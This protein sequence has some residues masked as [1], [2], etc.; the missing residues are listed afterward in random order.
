MLLTY[1]YL[2]G[3]RMSGYQYYE[4]MNFNSSPYGYADQPTYPPLLYAHDPSI[5]IKDEPESDG[6]L[7]LDYSHASGQS[8]RMSF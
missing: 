1:L 8:S 7:L 4:S 5:H 6:T 2:P 3:F